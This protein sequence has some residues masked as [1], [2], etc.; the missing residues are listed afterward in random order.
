MKKKL[1]ERNKESVFLIDSKILH[2]EYPIQNWK[3][4]RPPDKQRIKEIKN[5]I[6]NNGFF[7]NRIYL[8]EIKT[9]TSIHYYCYDGN[10]R[11]EAIKELCE[12]NSLLEV[13]TIPEVVISI[14]QNASEE[15]VK[16]NFK[17]LNKGC[18]VPELYTENLSNEE[19]KNN[20]EYIVNKIITKFKNHKSS[21]KHARR[22]NFNKDT[23][24]QNIF[25]KIKDKNIDKDEFYESILKLNKKYS[26]GVHLDLTKFQNKKYFKK[27]QENNCYLFLKKD[28]TEDIEI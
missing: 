8:A 21:S 12:E 25:E 1:Y 22:P 13:Q 18:P 5:I 27:C 24:T 14:I 3:Y 17:N 6:S 16:E 23:L 4:N 2:K 9:D 20:V 15:E 28:F 10:H 11:R 26:L 7:D 19:I